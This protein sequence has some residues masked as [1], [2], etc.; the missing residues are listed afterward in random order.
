MHIVNYIISIENKL[1]L[2]CLLLITSIS[3]VPR[4]PFIFCTCKI[5]IEMCQ[6]IQKERTE[7][8]EAEH[9]AVYEL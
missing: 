8:M 1:Y 7:N 9:S 5:I 6:E 4:N 3:Y 2:N